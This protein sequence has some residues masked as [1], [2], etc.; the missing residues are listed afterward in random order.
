[1]HAGYKETLPSEM[2]ADE[3]PPAPCTSCIRAATH[4]SPPPPG[5]DRATTAPL[6]Q[7]LILGYRTTAD[8]SIPPNQLGTQFSLHRTATPKSIGWQ[9]SRPDGC[10]IREAVSKSPSDSTGCRPT[11]PA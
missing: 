10:A 3:I 1:D 9:Q 5:T 7:T 2:P 11:C 6:P 8:A 4:V